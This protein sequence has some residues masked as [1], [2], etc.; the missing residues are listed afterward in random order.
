MYQNETL[1]RRL[2]RR[3]AR[4]HFGTFFCTKSTSELFVWYNSVQMESDEQNLDLSEEQNTK[5][6]ALVAALDA[7]RASIEED[8]REELQEEWTPRLDSADYAINEG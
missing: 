6:A 4:S 8:V 3:L 5:L 1:L 2:A 7:F